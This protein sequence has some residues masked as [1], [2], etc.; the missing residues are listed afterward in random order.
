MTFPTL[1]RRA[2]LLLAALAL[3]GC[4]SLGGKPDIAAEPIHVMTSGGFTAAYNELTPGYEKANGRKV[5][6]AYGASM[7]AASDSIPSRL[8]RGE[9]ADIVILARPALDALVAQGKVVSGSQV[10]LVRSS[11]GF[12]VRTGTPKPDIS[13]VDALKRTLLAAP[14]IAYSASAS[15]TY[16]ETE[17]LKKLGIEDQV[18][19]KS[20]R[21]LSERVGTVVAR[22]DAAL[23]LQQVSELLPIKG[24]DYIGPL[25]AEVQR[26]TVFSAGIAT[27]AKQPEAARQLIRYMN[28]PAAAPVIERTGLEAI[29]ARGP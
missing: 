18:K 27:G 16:Y 2:A 3:A 7:G 24:I 23:G 29:V 22:G 28:S 17:L 10:D 4:G 11:I 19:P 12:A 9:P 1:T 26:V 13:T 14:S 8:A 6:T 21:I 5:Q 15:G 25:P 20:Q